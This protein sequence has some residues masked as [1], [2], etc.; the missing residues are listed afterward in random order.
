MKI[1]LITKYFSN[2]KSR[3]IFTKGSVI[4]EDGIDKKY[5][6]T[7]FISKSKDNTTIV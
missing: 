7:L 1:F 6:V 3:E 5:I 2:G 4:V